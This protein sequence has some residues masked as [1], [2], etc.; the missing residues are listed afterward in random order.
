MFCPYEMWLLLFVLCLFPSFDVFVILQTFQWWLSDR[1]VLTTQSINVFSLDIYN[2]LN[3]EVLPSW[4]R[5]SSKDTRGRHLSNRLS[6][7]HTHTHTHTHIYIYIYI[8]QNS[9]NIVLF[10]SAVIVILKIIFWKCFIHYFSL[11]QHRSM[12]GSS[13]KADL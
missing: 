4:Q 10:P 1:I 6:L 5:L 3:F 2:W 8:K 9:V 11:F 13:K 12:V 7:L